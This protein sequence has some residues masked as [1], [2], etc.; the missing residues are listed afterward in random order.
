MDPKAE[1]IAAKDAEI[2]NILT[3]WGFISGFANRDIKKAQIKEWLS[4]FLPLEI[5]DAFLILSKI[6]VKEDRLIRAI[7]YLP[8]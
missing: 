4:N 3:D 2:E 6:Q 8:Y 1:K 5:D 7:I